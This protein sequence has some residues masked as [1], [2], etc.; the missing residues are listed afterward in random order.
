MWYKK[1]IS[2]VALF[3]LLIGVFPVS[4]PYVD[5]SWSTQVFA[6]G[7]DTDGDGVNNDIDIDDDNDGILD[8]VECP[9]EYG[10]PTTLN[11]RGLGWWFGS[12]S[13]TAR[14]SWIYD[15]EDLYNHGDVGAGV[16]PNGD[17][18]SASAWLA[19]GHGSSYSVTWVDQNTLAEAIADNDYIWITFSTQSYTQPFVFSGI[20]FWWLASKTAVYPYKLSLAISE[21]ASFSTSTI[22]LD[23]AINNGA[24]NV[25]MPLNA[26]R[27]LVAPSKTYY[28][29][30]YVYDA[31][32]SDP[33]YP[34]E[35]II[36]D[37]RFFVDLYDADYCDL[38]G[39]GVINSQDLDS[40]N[41][42]ISDLREAGIPGSFDGNGDG[43]APLSSTHDDG[44]IANS[45]AWNGLD[46][47]MENAAWEA[48][49]SY[50]P[51][52]SYNTAGDNLPDFLDLDSDD[53]GIPDSV[54]AKTT[55]A[56]LL[57]PNP[58]DS[59]SDSD[60]DGILDIFDANWWFAALGSYSE[61]VVFSRPYDHDDDGTPDYID[62][63][64]DDDTFLDNIERGITS[65]WTFSYADPDGTITDSS[66]LFSLFE[67]IDSDMSELDYRSVQSNIPLISLIGSWSVV[68]PV[69]NT[70]TDS[71]ALATD[72]E[73][74]DTALTALITS[75]GAVDDSVIGDYTITYNVTDSAWNDASAV[76]RNISVTD[77]IAPVL[78]LSGA[79]FMTIG[80]NSS[81]VE[82]GLSCSDNYDVTC[83][84]TSTGSIDTSV[85]G[86]YILSYNAM[87][88]SGNT[89]ATLT[90]TIII[91]SQNI[92]VLTLSGAQL[93]IIEQHETYID[94]WATAS[95]MEDGDISWNITSSGSVDTSIVWDYTLS[96]N[97]IDSDGNTGTWITRVVRVVDATTDSDNDGLPDLIELQIWTD[98]TQDDS[99]GDGTTDDNN[100]KDNISPIIELAAPNNGDA[101]GDGQ[102]DAIQNEVSSRP[103]S[104]NNQYNALEVSN[105]W[106]SSCGQINKFVSMSESSLSSQD[107]WFE[108]D[109][110][111]WDFEIACSA[112]WATAD[113]Q[114]YL[115]TV[116]DTSSWIYRK[117]NT[118]TNTYTDISSIVSYSTQTV[119]ST[120]VT[121][122][123]YSITDGGIHDED[124]LANGI[125]I[126]PSGP[127]LAI[128]PVVPVTPVVATPTY[129]GGWT[130]WYDRCG[131]LGDL[132]GDSYD[133]ICEALNSAPE[134]ELS[135]EQITE[136]LNNEN[137]TQ[138]SDIQEESI[139]VQDEAENAPVDEASPITEA[140]QASEE[141]I[142]DTSVT[143]DP[144]SQDRVVV[145]PELISEDTSGADIKQNVITVDE[146][147]SFETEA[148]ENLDVIS[149]DQETD[150]F[151]PVVQNTYQLPDNSYYRLDR[152][153][154]TCDVIADIKNPNYVFP[155][156][157][158]FSDIWGLSWQQDILK[159]AHID[160]VDGYS[161]G[162]FGP[163][164][165]M[166]RAEFLKTILISHCYMYADQDTS[167]LSYVD[168]A[169]DSWQAKIVKKSQWLWLVQW[170]VLEYDMNLLNKSI[171]KYSD[172][173]VILHLKRT[174][175][176]L[177]LYSGVVSGKWT[178]DLITSIYNFQK[179]KWIVT[180]QNDSNAWVW[181]QDTRQIF[182]ETYPNKSI[183]IFRADDVISRSEAIKILMKVSGIR[184]DTPQTL[185]YTDVTVDWHKKYIEN[186]QSLGVL[187][188]T[189]DA[190][191]FHPNATLLRQEVVDMIKSFVSLYH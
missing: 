157:W 13:G 35:I 71:W 144:S 48:G 127:S 16:N 69:G 140:I 68:H 77:S 20:D 61:P 107:S 94:A 184:S 72:V 171:W 146:T 105:A 98:T 145:I 92:P 116:Y 100:D 66:S 79:T 125:I 25:L 108:Y 167:D 57:Y 26:Q 109:L 161:D 182:F 47:R 46:D 175:H 40:D 60:G 123:S 89:A 74:D 135:Y 122:V 90:R 150:L 138:D 23:E 178:Q 6:S 2:Q 117:F 120:S 97:I 136:S 151:T 115:D 148:I 154:E 183:D 128:T 189:D 163:N 33:L 56:Y 188:P 59:S 36:D 176:A 185:A 82:P 76:T 83:S 166:T 81:Y 1:I 158:V 28:M 10:T 70:Y 113:I 96:Y 65:F 186:W 14:V 179:S 27:Y 41:D 67:N 42:G 55:P 102:Q 114:I 15:L 8:T 180:N 129:S 137:N 95:D 32:N 147:P 73:D 103:N 121:V 156:Q 124:G 63:D 39:D 160:I 34:D 130:G 21:D 52:D 174:L 190:Y 30:L 87:D 54:E 119:W 31:P 64:S 43:L 172:A 142:S 5:I 162:S 153:F 164:Q 152:S 50:V 19:H 51:I 11:A 131:I 132:S 49:K 3:A 18:I 169:K 106:V 85:A 170:D 58:I 165:A 45:G 159:F 93:V 141:D 78:T 134:T 84:Y 22:I 44:S 17:G 88:T 53:D 75:T 149:D 29:R 91:E 62:L 112:T 12:T 155:T 177:G 104:L 118:T 191:S 126:D 4:L 7:T 9:I 173:T 111:L 187:D 101:N 133:G 99:D 37:M 24:A 38:D 86:T 143:I 181:S 168:L 80:L 139:A 110:G